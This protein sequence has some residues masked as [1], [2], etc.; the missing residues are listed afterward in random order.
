MYES[1]DMSWHQPTIFPVDQDVIELGLKIGGVAGVGLVQ[2]AVQIRNPRTNELLEW[3]S[4]IEM[5]PDAFLPRVIELL[6]FGHDRLLSYLS[7][8]PE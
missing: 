1:D 4:F 7:P 3:R 8:F 6:K 2:C 5:D